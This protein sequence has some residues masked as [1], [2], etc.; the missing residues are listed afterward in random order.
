MVYCALISFA[1]VVEI[2]Y[3]VQYL[4]ANK[5]FVVVGVGIDV[6]VV[7]AVVF[8]SIYRKADAGFLQLSVSVDSPLRSHKLGYGMS[9][10]IVYCNHKFH[11]DVMEMLLLAN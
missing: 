10:S 9:V 2:I 8:A 7:A 3:L 11:N 1:A 6:V 4:I 5:T